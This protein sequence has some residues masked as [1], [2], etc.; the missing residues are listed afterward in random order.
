VDWRYQLKPL[1]VMGFGAA[2]HQRHMY[3]YFAGAMVCVSSSTPPRPRRYAG[4]RDPARR[5]G[6]L[7]LAPSRALRRRTEGFA[8]KDDAFTLPRAWHCYLS[9]DV[10]A[11]LL[12]QLSVLP[13]HNEPLP[14][15]EYPDLS[16][17]E[18][19]K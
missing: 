16:Q 13:R 11:R 1:M 9:P 5:Q 8:P 4:R 7:L 10:A 2:L 12:W 19:F 18:A 17:L 3:P 14:N 6:R 15:D